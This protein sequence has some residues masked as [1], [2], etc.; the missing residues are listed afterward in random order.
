MI[1]FTDFV[2]GKST[3]TMGEERNQNNGID[4]LL[5]EAMTARMEK[6]MDSRI[7]SFRQELHQARNHRQ[8]RTRKEETCF[9]QNS[10][11]IK[12]ESPQ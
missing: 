9:R 5:L 12:N 11:V 8:R 2:F 10:Y 1:S 4:Q 6:M 7:D 3:G